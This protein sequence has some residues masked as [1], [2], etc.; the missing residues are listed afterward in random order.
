MSVFLEDLWKVFVQGLASIAFS[1]RPVFETDHENRLE[2]RRRGSP[3]CV[4]IGA[5]GSDWDLGSS[6]ASGERSTGMKRRNGPAAKVRIKESCFSSLPIV[7]S[8]LLLLVS[9]A[10]APGDARISVTPARLRFSISGGEE[11][12]A[13]IT[14]LNHGEEEITLNG[15]VFCVETYHGGGT[16]LVAGGDSGWVSLSRQ[17]VFLGPGGRERIQVSVLPPPGAEPGL[18]RWAVAFVQAGGQTGDI[19]VV[20]GLAVLLEAEILPAGN[21]RNQGK[22]GYLWW[23][24]A[25]LMI[26]AIVSLSL[27]KV[28]R[29]STGAKAMGSGGGEPT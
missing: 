15:E 26:F 10:P 28:R 14:L 25:G 13:E 24:G 23:A 12:G 3:G 21:P 9:A 6:E 20:G 16:R 7:L 8:T 27:G 2:E 18:R 1:S 29:K 11:G 19:G 22:V 5:Q 4:F 17:E